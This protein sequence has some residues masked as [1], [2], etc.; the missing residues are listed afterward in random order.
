MSAAGAYGATAEER[1]QAVL[2]VLAVTPCHITGMHAPEH[3]RRYLCDGQKAKMLEA[4]LA[5]LGLDFGDLPKRLHPQGECGWCHRVP[6]QEEYRIGLRATWEWAGVPLTEE[7]AAPAPDVPQGG[8][9]EAVYA[10]L[11]DE[12]QTWQAATA[13]LPF[14]STRYWAAIT[15]LGDRVEWRDVS[16]RRLHK[17]NTETPGGGGVGDFLA[18]ETEPPPPGHAPLASGHSSAPGGTR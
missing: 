7:L 13:Q 11:T 17:G 2:D 15:T 6:S 9:A 4:V 14:G 3:H 8:D 10:V 16:A 5:A 12:W 1:L 18:V